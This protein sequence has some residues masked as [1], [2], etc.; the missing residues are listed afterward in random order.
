MCTATWLRNDKGYDLFFNRDERHTRKPATAPEIHQRNGVKFIAPTDGDHG[1][2][3]I[4]VNQF[5]LSLCLLNAYE[6]QTNKTDIHFISRGKIIFDLAECRTLSEVRAHLIDKDLSSFQP[7]RLFG[8]SN[9]ETSLLLEWDGNDMAINYT[10]DELIPL[11]SSSFDPGNVVTIRRKLYSELI[12]ENGLSIDSLHSFH[13][14]H[15]PSQSAYSVCMHR[16]DAKTV[17][18]SH[19]SVAD[20]AIRFSYYLGSPC[21]YSEG[22]VQSASVSF[23]VIRPVSNQQA[24]AGTLNLAIV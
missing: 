12:S 19:I 23:P 1:G 15:I 22:K 10:A 17:S 20:D 9:D 11:S 16:D 8:I 14:S 5:G 2:T 18:F 21:R 7:F 13:C 3:W 6:K 4:A 24:K